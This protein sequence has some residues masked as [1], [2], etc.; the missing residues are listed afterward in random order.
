MKKISALLFGMVCAVAAIF[1]GC[2]PAASG[3]FYSLKE[4]YDSG[5]LTRED[6]MSIAYYH[7]GG[8]QCNEDIMGEDYA[9]IPK[10]PSELSEETSKKIRSTAAHGYNKQFSGRNAAAD[11]FSIVE[12]CGTYGDCVVVMMTDIYSAYTDAEEIG[13]VADVKIYY[14]NGN[15]LTVWKEWE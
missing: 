1:A 6:I 8:I 11:D 14:R 15:S 12:Y 10:V 7:N 4:A 2:A 9:P 5:Y 3:T 13:G